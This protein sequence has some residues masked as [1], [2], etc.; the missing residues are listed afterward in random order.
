[1]IPAKKSLAFKIA[2]LTLLGTA[3][4]F[5]AVFFY[6]YAISRQTV[7]KTVED[8]TRYLTLSTVHK[9]ENTLLGIEKVPLYL[10]ASLETQV[11]TRD[12]LLKWIENVLHTNP[13]IYGATVAYR[14]LC[15]LI[16]NPAITPPISA[17]KM[18]SFGLMM[19]KP[20]SIIFSG[21]GT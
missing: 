12:I 13:E 8:N 6:N 20:P 18:T 1:M 15:S 17:G 21:T 11:Y 3:C 10:A 4:I 16:R 14:A 9:I 19:R 7:L 5:F 2:S